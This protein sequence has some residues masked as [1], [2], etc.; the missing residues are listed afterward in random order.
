MNMRMLAL[1]NL[2]AKPTRFIATVLAVIVGT[3]F[4]AG[5][6]ILTDS[7][8]TTLTN[9]LNNQL[10]NVDAAV[11]GDPPA[12][13]GEARGGRQNRQGGGGANAQQLGVDT[14]V[15]A[16]R[17]GSVQGVPTV[18]DAAGIV[19]GVISVLD[20]D[21]NPLSRQTV[22]SLWVPVP[23]LS[24]YQVIEGVGPAG[25]GQ[26]AIDRTTAD[27]DNL[28]VGQTVNLSTSAGR[29][30][31]R[32]VGIVKYGAQAQSGP[33][34]DVVVSADDAF[35]WLNSGK[36][37][38]DAIY[39][40]A[41]DGTDPTVLVTDIDKAVGPGYQVQTGDAFREDRAGI[42][43][44][45]ADPIGIG[46]Q[47][48]AY[49]ALFVGLFIIYNTFSIIVAQRVREFALLR[50][51][52]ASRKQI[53][54]AVRIEAV[55]IG[56]IA[57]AFGFLLGI[58]L[59]EALVHFVPQF[60]G[61]A[62]GVTL[63]LRVGAVLQVLLAGTIIT[64]LSAM[65]PSW[66]AGRTNPI[67]AMRSVAVDRSGTSRG[68]AIVG[69]VLLGFGLFMLIVGTV[70]S[71]FW[72]MAVGPPFL[73][74]GVLVGG[75]VL[76][77]A[78]GSIAERIVRRVPQSTT[79]RLG[80]ENVRRN[81]SR[82]AT[83]ANA[84][85]I[86]VFLVVLV[87]AGGGAVRDYATNVLS[88]FGGPDF[89]V[90]SIG[91]GFP[92]DYIAKVQAIPGVTETATIYP[93]VG[94]VAGAQGNVAVGAV[95]FGQMSALGLA[96]DQS[97]VGSGSLAN[98]GPADMVVSSFIA[99]NQQL[100]L[101]DTVTITYGNGVVGRV[102][103]AALTKPSVSLVFAYVSPAAATKADPALQPAQLAISVS[104][105]QETEVAIALDQVTNRYS[106]IRVLP[107]NFLAEIV[108]NIFNALISSVNA[109]L[110]V[111]VIIALFGIVNTL[112]LSVT[113]RRHEVGLLRAV[114]MT[115]SQLR[116]TV[117]LEA[118]VVSLIGSVLGIGFGLLVAWCLTRPFLS[119]QSQAF[120]WPVAQ[121]GLVLL[122]GVIIGVVAAII[123]AWRAGRLDVLD[124]IG[125]E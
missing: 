59:F 68:R 22:G 110:S 40:T 86:G 85:V 78:L 25:A 56:L 83:T 44:A 95:D 16:S 23:G 31:G 91:N 84:L 2:R 66:R 12:A 53:G 109:L 9:N 93:L 52:G 101:G 1:R 35:A 18:A 63:Q 113:E 116:S 104:H 88:R 125:V 32:I 115:R 24:P 8:G 27:R 41:R 79:A 102:R 51:V 64:L 39:A 58:A 94:T 107:G 47:F 30:P 54:R 50:A 76:V 114:G 33:G 34:G 11:T 38:Y 21:G 17:L 60:Q 121:M 96:I 108:T 124:A 106:S 36:A 89:T 87:T 20:A 118:L 97:A 119:D 105:G 99:Q 37:Q 42:I 98:L 103:I 123:P 117:R 70:T 49:L 19:T 72:V 15:P 75:P 82:S 29:A 6:H 81:P 5:A 3:G 111:A 48:F 4:L 7:L 10:Q 122:L 71:N 65:V 100:K 92:P 26:I 112:I 69:I 80:V 13:A 90:L 77:A 55:L 73:F 28:S 74:L 67:E 14:N 62:G 45:L 43:G 46:L 61:I 120:S 57:S